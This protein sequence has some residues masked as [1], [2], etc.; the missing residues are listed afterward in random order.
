M[1]FHLKST[2]SKVFTRTDAQMKK[3]RLSPNQREKTEEVYH[4]ETEAGEIVK[5]C[6]DPNE[7]FVWLFFGLTNVKP[8]ISNKVVEALFESPEATPTIIEV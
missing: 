6:A 3:Y 1:K 2:T 8:K 4:Y 5:F 7:P